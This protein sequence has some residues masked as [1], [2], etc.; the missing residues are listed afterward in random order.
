LPSRRTGSST[1]RAET[2]ATPAAMTSVIDPACSSAPRRFA[3]VRSS[4]RS[5]TNTNTAMS[6]GRSRPRVS[7]CTCV[8]ISTGIWETRNELPRVARSLVPC[9]TTTWR[10]GAASDS[11]I[12]LRSASVTDAPLGHSRSVVPI[13]SVMRS[14]TV[15]TSC[16]SAC[17]TRRS[18][19]CRTSW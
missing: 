19:S 2:R 16:T 7:R 10:S 13:G 11:T 5:E 1:L 12:A 17:S 14:S 15:R 9:R 18:S 6:V 4:S 8:P 3:S